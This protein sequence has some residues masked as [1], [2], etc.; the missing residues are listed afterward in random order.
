MPFVIQ[1]PTQDDVPEI[2]NMHDSAMATDTFIGKL[3]INVE[4]ML[5][6]QGS[7]DYFTKKFTQA[8]HMGFE[9][10]KVVDTDTG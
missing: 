7:I 5:R 8:R 2:V 4:P 1:R 3:F 6:L 10:W 9:L